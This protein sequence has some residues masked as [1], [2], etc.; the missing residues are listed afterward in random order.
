MDIPC[1]CYNLDA[2]KSITL[3]FFSI[4]CFLTRIRPII[5]IGLFLYYFTSE[6][7][8]L[9]QYRHII[10]FR[11]C[12]KHDSRNYSSVNCCSDTL[13]LTLLPIS[14]YNRRLP[15]HHVEY[16]RPLTAI[17]T[18]SC[19]LLLLATPSCEEVDLIVFS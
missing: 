1:K 12:W 17:A 15:S 4:M 5:Q 13:Y 10:D 11:L 16:V 8:Y 3:H 14:I 9:R 19:M 7:V 2:W 18:L 6:F